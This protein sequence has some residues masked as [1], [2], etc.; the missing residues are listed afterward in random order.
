MYVC[1]MSALC[2]HKISL[3]RH[4]SFVRCCADIMRTLCR[5]CADIYLHYLHYMSALYPSSVFSPGC[6]FCLQQ[7]CFQWCQ[8]YCYFSKRVIVNGYNAL[9]QVDLSNKYT[10]LLFYLILTDLIDWLLTCRLKYIH[11]TVRERE[12]HQFHLV[13][14]DP[15]DSHQ[16]HKI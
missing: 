10:D 9:T 16:I 13:H 8:R 14:V 2:P 6:C 15:A 3:V 5:H 1:T 7:W 12:R 4:I 11:W